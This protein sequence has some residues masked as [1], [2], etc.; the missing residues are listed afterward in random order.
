ML[1]VVPAAVILL[2][3]PRLSGRLS[4]DNPRFA[5][6][7]LVVSDAGRPR[8]LRFVHPGDGAPHFGLVVQASQGFPEAVLDI[9]GRWPELG[10]SFAGFCTANG[11]DRADQA[12][13]SW[14]AGERELERIGL[15]ADALADVVL[16]PV[17][18]SLDQINLG[19]RVVVGVG[20]NF[21]DHALEA[22]ESPAE[23]FAFAKAVEP[24]SPYAP[25]RLQTPPGA[26]PSTRPLADYEVELAMVL[27]EDV[28]LERLPSDP[29]EMDSRVAWL[30]A[31]DVSERWSI[32]VH[33]DAGFTAGKSLPGYLPLGPWMV[34]GR[35]LAL[36]SGA[37]DLRLWLLVEEALP[38]PGGSW[39]QLA[40]T[41][42]MVRRP[43]EVLRL[44]A[45][46]HRESVR[47]DPS[48]IPRGIV[49]EREG[50]PVLPAGSLVLMGTPEGTA[51]E[52]PTA[53]DKARL[54]ARA[55]LSTERARR[56]FAAH[57]DRERE[58]LGFLAAG[59]VVESCVEGLGCQRWAVVA[60]E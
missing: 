20:L 12:L 36:A 16:P 38:H 55:N 13:A 42:S 25:I 4:V 23:S 40:S 33:G 37:A 1:A 58:A 15:A 32:V 56:R 57:L 11:F 18:L 28:D 7:P 48:G 2:R 30:G 14:Q 52:A 39:R 60:D 31:N 10:G 34:H 47:P 53:W 9:T 17:D 8:I 6:E 44:L 5:H 19:E 41:G 26:P 24:T 3:D 46:I 29:A 21:S 22:G 27:L 54:I 59:D 50:R 45:A 35:H 51:V 49:A 43:L